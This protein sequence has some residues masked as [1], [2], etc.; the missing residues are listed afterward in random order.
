ML[1]ADLCKSA[2]AL[3]P[4]DLRCSFASPFST[5]A[6][7]PKTDRQA[8]EITSNDRAN[9]MRM[10]DEDDEDDEDDENDEDDEDDKDG[11]DGDD[12]IVE[13]EESRR[14]PSYIYD[15][16]RHY[17][18]TFVGTRTRN[19]DGEPHQTSVDVVGST[20]RV[21]L[22]NYSQRPSSISLGAWTLY[23]QSMARAQGFDVAAPPVRLGI[24]TSNLLQSLE[25]DCFDI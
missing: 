25:R 7:V 13:L 16:L 4:A 5:T 15:T 1:T 3:Y 14:I 11:D 10:V 12:D 21:R 22:H 18:A 19:V 6:G 24:C 17:M 9:M 8:I 20:R 23:I 2:K